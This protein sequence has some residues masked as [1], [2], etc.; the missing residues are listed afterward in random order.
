MQHSTEITVRA[1]DEHDVPRDTRGATLEWTS[2]PDNR[3]IRTDTI[4]EHSTIRS[5]KLNAPGSLRVIARLPTYPTYYDTVGVN[6]W[7]DGAQHWPIEL[8]RPPNGEAEEKAWMTRDWYHLWGRR[9]ADVCLPGSHD[10]GMYVN[11]HT[12][13]GASSASVLNQSKSIYD[14]LCAGARFLDLRPTNYRG[15]WYAGHFNPDAPTFGDYPAGGVGGSMDTI[16]RDIRRFLTETSNE[17]IILA[18]RKF[19]DTGDQKVALKLKRKMARTF[20]GYLR[21]KLRGYLYYHSQIDDVGMVMTGTGTRRQ[22]NPMGWELEAVRR[23]GRV[24]P[25]YYGVEKGSRLGRNGP[26][27]IPPIEWI[28]PDLLTDGII[29]FREPYE[30]DEDK[31]DIWKHQWDEFFRSRGN[32]DRRFHNFQLVHRRWQPFSE[33]IRSRGRSVNQ[34]MLGN[35]SRMNNVINRL[36][37][38]RLIERADWRRQKM[39]NTITIDEFDPRL[40]EFCRRVTR[41]DDTR[42]I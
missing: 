18:I 32:E 14:Q 30:G 22:P 36:R 2:Y 6:G 10:A 17:I 7:D 3:P 37:E 12:Q 26:W 4:G 35:Q 19:Y 21:Q 8:R 28:E 9:F 25:V 16:M 42:T 39:L 24:I 33:S 38:Q 31:E 1:I 23:F 29:S 40:T 34:H 20:H 5:P 11:T 13:G 41:V 27:I 15:N